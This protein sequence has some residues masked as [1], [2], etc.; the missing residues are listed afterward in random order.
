M[1]VGVI[2]L[3]VRLPGNHSLKGKR[4]VVKSLIGQVRS[5]FNVAVSEIALNDVWQKAEIGISTIGNSQPIIN[6]VLDKIMEFIQR[7][8]LVE[9]IDTEIEIIHMGK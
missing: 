8:C 1:I 2:R 3:R 4:R 5:H 6:S 9:I 7:T